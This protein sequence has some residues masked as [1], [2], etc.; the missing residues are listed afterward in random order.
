MKKLFSYT[1][2]LLFIS[3]VG[4]ACNAE[5]CFTPSINCASMIIRE[6]RQAKAEIFVQAYG[7]TD[8][9]IITALKAAKVRKISVIVLLDK[10]QIN[11]KNVPLK[12]ILRSGIEVYSDSKPPIAHN[13][14]MI[15]DKNTLIT[16]SYNFTNNAK[17]N[18]ENVL[19]LHDKDLIHKYKNNFN[20]RKSA[21][22]KIKKRGV[23]NEYF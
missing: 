23:N 4:A 1:L 6:I 19:I 16:G 20:S 3:N 10:S 17:R 11:N 18:A 21:S 14:V 22:T 15:I 9:D 2:A 13:K 12:D 8:K 7:F 5:V